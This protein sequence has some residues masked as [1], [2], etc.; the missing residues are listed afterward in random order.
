MRHMTATSCGYALSRTV[1]G[2][3]IQT[4]IPG[5]MARVF[6]TKGRRWSGTYCR[7]DNP[8][9]DLT[10]LN[11]HFPTRDAAVQA[12]MKMVLS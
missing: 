4:N 8:R 6:K 7:G 12:I 3:M 9:V 11:I 10:K 2:W 1:N 5:V